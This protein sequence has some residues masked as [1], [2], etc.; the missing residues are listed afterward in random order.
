MIWHEDRGHIPSIYQIEAN[1]K[2]LNM[3]R[4][5]LTSAWRNIRKGKLYSAINIA[6]LA[7][8]LA[9]G[10]MLLLWVQNETGYDAFLKD[11]VQIYRVNV[12]FK[13]QKNAGKEVVY[14]MSPP[15]VYREAKTMADVKAVSRVMDNGTARFLKANSGQP[16]KLS[17]IYVDKEFLS[18]FS[19][20]LRLGNRATIWQDPHSIVLTEHAAN[21][22]FGD[23]N[24]IGQV[25]DY[26]GEKMTVTGVLLDFP[27]KSSLQTDVLLPMAS[28]KSAYLATHNGRDLDED[29]QN[30]GMATY[31]LLHKNAAAQ[32][33][34]AAITQSWLKLGDK[35]LDFQ[36]QPLT[37]IH[38]IQ[39]N[40]D[41]SALRLVQIFMGIVVL[42]FL[43]A[44]INYINISTA[45][46]LVRS[47]EVGVKKIMGAL[48]SQLFIQFAW[49]TILM[50]GISLLLAIGLIYLLM[51][52]YN[53]ISGK[54]LQ[55]N[56]SDLRL[57]KT[58]MLV[59][60][61]T[62][63][64]SSIYPS[65]LLSSFKPLQALKGKVGKN[66]SANNF[67]KALVVFQF[68]MAAVLLFMTMVMG[69]QMDYIRHKNIGYDKDY[70]FTVRFPE[71]AIPHLEAISSSLR[72]NSSIESVGLSS[73]EDLTDLYVSTTGIKWQGKDPNSS[74][75]IYSLSVDNQFLPTMK[76]HLTA[77]RNFSGLAPDSSA[78]I[79]NQTAVEQMGLKTPY[80]G[81]EV[82][83]AGRK[84]TITGIVQ[85]FNFQSLK[86][87]VSPLIMYVKP[88]SRNTLY[89]R[90]SAKN[91]TAAIQ[92]AATAYQ[93]YKTNEAPFKYEFLDKQ[94]EALYSSDLR[95][96]VL[97]KSFASIAIFISCLGL[98]GLATYN[99]ESRIKEIGI[100]KV[101][102]ASVKS[103]IGLIC[104]EFLLLVILAI[105]MSAPLS[106]LLADK[107]LQNFAFQ[108]KIGVG[109][110]AQVLFLLL[111][112]TLIT[113]ALN[114]YKT[115]KSNL[116]PHLKSE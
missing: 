73:A 2:I 72:Q 50:F 108:A 59:V 116:L 96:G 8:G 80:V 81:Q 10:M 44:C 60:L 86:S 61:G 76:M 106:Y 74:F 68:F 69:R 31:V 97:F 52:L 6:G 114:V 39:P 64:L 37:D 99:A 95:V 23:S 83:F 7:I 54:S 92:A 88:A 55:F 38:L 15:K 89:I 103:I 41:N 28:Y 32:N 100:R 46:S 30:F 11:A 9:S 45:R 70:V 110:F 67:R 3:W 43:I 94:F 20:K 91:T 29:R 111:L 62:L 65:L 12:Q 75:L 57:W 13:G 56:L 34:A 42:I 105:V 16:F 49:E 109:V 104:K 66:I 33:V 58:L 18:V 101:L 1:V 26:E 40:G 77:G 85:D 113:M 35:R 36:L 47:R 53:Y 102:G 24:P 87:A 21:K 90:T 71:G 5:Y 107:W 17:S 93:P 98:F 84:C 22:L 51:P 82:S 25:M 63:L 14:P 27:S 4:H 115:A 48:R 112:I 79:L 78:V 19:Y